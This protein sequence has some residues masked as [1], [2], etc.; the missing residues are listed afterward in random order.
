MAT[1]LEYYAFSM[2][3]KI[4]LGSSISPFLYF[5]LYLNHLVS[6]AVKYRTMIV[7][8]KLFVVPLDSVSLKI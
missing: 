5:V 6:T 7:L 1:R 4:T 8:G 3:F 2:V